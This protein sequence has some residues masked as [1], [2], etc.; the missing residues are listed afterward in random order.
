M[1]QNY[2]IQNRWVPLPGWFSQTVNWCTS[3]S[4]GVVIHLSKVDQFCFHFSIAQPTPAEMCRHDGN[5]DS[6]VPKPL[7]TLC[8][9]GKLRPWIMNIWLATTV[10][11]T[12]SL[13]AFATLCLSLKLPEWSFLGLSVS[14]RIQANLSVGWPF[15]SERILIQAFSFWRRAT[16]DLDRSINFAV[17]TAKDTTTVDSFL[18]SRA[19]VAR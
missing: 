11:E 12:K 9:T 19:T 15:T 6:F 5:P 18:C 1:I 13:E 4:T 8:S 7:A 2:Q 17:W 10:P 14:V 16:M 3:P